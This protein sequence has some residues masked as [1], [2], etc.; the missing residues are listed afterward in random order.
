MMRTRGIVGLAAIVAGLLAAAPAQAAPAWITPAVDVS[1]DT[2]TNYGSPV[3][4]MGASGDSIAIYDN[5]GLSTSTIK[6]VFRPAGGA[7]GAPQTVTT[8]MQAFIHKAVAVD[9]TGNAYAIWT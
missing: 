4:A 8:N 7:Y 6:S 9:A 5:G 2:A 1:A 3:V